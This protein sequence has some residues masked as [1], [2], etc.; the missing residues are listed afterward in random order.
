[1]AKKKVRQNPPAMKKNNSRSELDKCY[2]AA[3]K[4][5]RHYGLAPE[6]IDVFSK[7]Q[8]EQLFQKFYQ[9][10]SIRP[11]KERTIPRQYVVS[12][13]SSIYQFMKT[14]FWG[15]PANHLS[16]MELAT[17][18]LSFLSNINYHYENN[19]YADGTPQWDAA[20]RICEQFDGDE[21]I[22]T[23]FKEVLDEVWSM[24]RSYSRVN[25]RMYGFYF[26]CDIIPLSHSGG[27]KCRLAIQITAQ[28]CETK[29]FSY[30]NVYRKAFQ[31]FNTPDG[32]Y[33]PSPVRIPQS[34]VYNNA[35]NEKDFNIYIQ[36]HALHRF[37]ERLDLFSPT[38][39]NLL[40]QYTFT[41][42]LIYIHT[43]KRDMFICTIEGDHT[44]GYFTFFIQGDDL[45]INTFL[46]LV[47]HYAPEGKKL[48]KALSLSKE[49][50]TYL[51]MDKISFY[52]YVDFEQIPKL[53][54]ALID[55]DIWPTKL[56]LERNLTDVNDDDLKLKASKT[57]S[58]KNFF[59]KRE[60]A[61][62][63]NYF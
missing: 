44:L 46:P 5:L 2:V 53:K 25:Y 28:D 30:N 31:I 61:Q 22:D 35:A 26:D 1:M 6:L 24:T 3:K 21:V 58:V 18:G 39:Q 36:S 48:Q 7:K 8:K 19:Y 59:N 16:Y 32:F 49:E 37:K 63:S 12:I 38:I 15:D 11:A 9:N 52:I 23:G 34:M 56:T 40:F 33:L 10:P 29:V 51:G 42:N 27:F 45:V 14:H 55:A 20:K 43:D 62:Q 54:Q 13:N 41:G 47:N 4:I 57:L 50:L 60:E 17:Y